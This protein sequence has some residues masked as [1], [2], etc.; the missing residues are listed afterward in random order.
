MLERTRNLHTVTK[1]LI[2]MTT[3]TLLIVV[4]VFGVT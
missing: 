1:R 4:G 2:V 3:F